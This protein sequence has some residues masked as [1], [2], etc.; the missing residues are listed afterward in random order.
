MKP[1]LSEDGGG[2]AQ[3]FLMNSGKMYIIARKK[4]QDMRH[5]A[6]MRG[7]W[8]WQIGAVIAFAGPDLERNERGRCQKIDKG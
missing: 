1:P 2:S 4:Q 7:V 3:P 5:S 6:M 8:Q